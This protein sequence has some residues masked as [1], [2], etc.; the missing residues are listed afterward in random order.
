MRWVD[1][2][3]LVLGSVLLVVAGACGD[4]TPSAPASPTPT[5]PARPGWQTVRV[6]TTGTSPANPLNHVLGGDGRGGA[7]V[8]WIANGHLESATFQ[9][10]TGWGSTETLDE[11]ADNRPA[12]IAVSAHGDAVVTW[13]GGSPGALVRRRASGSSSWETA[14]RL[15]EGFLDQ[16]PHVG[17]D[18]DGAAVLTWAESQ[19]GLWLARSVPGAGWEPPRVLQS[20]PYAAYH[21]AAVGAAGLTT[22]PYVFFR[23]TGVPNQVPRWQTCGVHF[24]A[25]GVLDTSVDCVEPPWRSFGSEIVAASAADGR[26]LAVWTEPQIYG[27]WP[28]RSAAWWQ[29]GLGWSE[30]TPLGSGS[31]DTAALAVDGRGA[32]I[33]LLTAAEPPAV[34]AYRFEANRG[35]LPA[36]NLLAPSALSSFS[37]SI[38]L[39][40]TGSGWATWDELFPGG[41]RVVARRFVR[42]AGWS[43]PVEVAVTQDGVSLA[44]NPQIVVDGRGGALIVWSEARPGGSTTSIVARQYV[45][46]A[47]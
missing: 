10:L 25:S 11:R 20:L 3:R 5:P 38:A 16:V 4:T 30:R 39:E 2:S 37:V 17:I 24:R 23:N 32:G 22:V 42:D 29:P 18:D 12:Q 35:W 9:A 14:V 7:V 31:G 19:T 26:T 1:A 13:I 21:N 41:N 33:V 15:G 36:E 47:E 28:E 8:A 44:S 46:P 6:V 43:S 27:G 40:P 45:A 34:S